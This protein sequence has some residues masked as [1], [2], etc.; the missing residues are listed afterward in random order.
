MLAGLEREHAT[1]GLDALYTGLSAIGN[2]PWQINKRV[3]QVLEQ[4]M[5]SGEDGPCGTGTGTAAG[6]PRVTAKSSVWV[7]AET[8][9]RAAAACV[10]VHV[11]KNS[12]SRYVDVV[13]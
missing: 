9:L 13:C 4:V 8:Y 3:L 2:V 12:T 10:Y 6:H 1:G 7:R 5:D 11:F